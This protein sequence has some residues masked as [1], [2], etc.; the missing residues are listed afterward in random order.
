MSTIDLSSANSADVLSLAIRALAPLVSAVGGEQ[1][2]ALLCSSLEQISPTDGSAVYRYGSGAFLEHDA[3]TTTY[4][5]DVDAYCSAAHLLDPFYR[6]AM[7]QNFRGFSHMDDL[8]PEAFKETDFY[9]QYYRLTGLRDEC[10]YILQLPR[11][12][13]LNIAL[14]RSSKLPMFTKEE[15]AIL[16]ALTP[17]IQSL[18]ESHW[19]LVTNEEDN[20]SHLNFQLDAALH[21]FGC[22]KLTP[23][24][25]EIIQLILQ[26]HSTLSA[27]EKLGISP[28]TVK[29]HRK[30]S[31]EKLDICSQSELFHLFIAALGSFDTYRGGDPLE[32]YY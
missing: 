29:I 18:C 23:R 3:S 25:S 19:A 27:A 28:G 5:D 32:G 2:P 1:F 16:K 30:R 4:P 15:L 26:G 8:S 31:Y 11:G 12:E 9:K 22:S 6:A 21:N 20:I 7:D 10:G 17:L 14:C 24:E 13:L